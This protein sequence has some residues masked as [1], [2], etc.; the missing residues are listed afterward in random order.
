MTVEARISPRNRQALAGRA[1]L[2]IATDA[3][4]VD[5]LEQIRYGV[6]TARRGGATKKDIVNTLALGALRRRITAKRNA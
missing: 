4:H 1:M 3:H 6:T 2:F 5:Q